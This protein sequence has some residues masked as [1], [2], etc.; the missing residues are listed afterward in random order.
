MVPDIQSEPER[1][2]RRSPDECPGKAASLL[3]LLRQRLRRSLRSLRII[4]ADHHHR[5]IGV[6]ESDH[7]CA[8][9]TWLHEDILDDT[10]R[11]G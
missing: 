4:P 8:P 3:C 11:R 6:I 10:P 1:D 2:R 7:S 9:M 5:W